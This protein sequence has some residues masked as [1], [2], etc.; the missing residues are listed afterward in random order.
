MYRGL[1]KVKRKNDHSFF[2]ILEENHLKIPLQACRP[3]SQ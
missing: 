1:R 2:V 3:F